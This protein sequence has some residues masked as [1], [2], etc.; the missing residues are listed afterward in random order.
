MAGLYC[1]AM[2]A[3][4]AQNRPI[5][6]V[7]MMGCGKST[8]GAVLASLLHRPFVD[9]DRQ[10]ESDSGRTIPQIFEADGESA[11]RDLEALTIDAVAVGDAVVALG[12]GAIAQPGAPE[13]LAKLGTVVYLRASLESL[14]RRVGAT[15]RRPLLAGLDEAERRGR[16]EAMLRDRESAYETAQLV[17]GTDD[18]GPSEIARRIAEGLGI[19][20]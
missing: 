4:E 10:I 13:R 12:G 15:E 19:E 9:V 7:G 18:Q 11:F 20:P 3:L 6:L 14:A 1:A 8:V 5:L 16:L 2:E 17:V